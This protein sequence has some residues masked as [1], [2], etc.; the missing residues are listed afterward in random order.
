MSMAESRNFSVGDALANA[1]D[2]FF[3]NCAAL[4]E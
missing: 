2:A 3:G 1:V 4:P